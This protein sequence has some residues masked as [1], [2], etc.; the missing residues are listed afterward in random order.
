M[1]GPFRTQADAPGV[2]SDFSAFVERLLLPAPRHPTECPRLVVDPSGSGRIY[3]FSAFGLYRS[4]DRGE[5][6][7]HLS[8]TFGNGPFA[9]GEIRFGEIDHIYAVAGQTTDGYVAG[10]DSAGGLVFSTLVG[11]RNSD[12]VNSV[13]LAPGGD[14]LIGGTTRSD[15]VLMAAGAAVNSNGAYEQGFL[16]RLSA[17]GSALLDFR[18]IGGSA[19]DSIAGLALLSN[20]ELAVAG[21]SA[22]RDRP[23]VSAD[24]FASGLAGS[25]DGFLGVYSTAGFAP[26]FFSFLG[27]TGANITTVAAGGMRAYLLG[28]FIGQQ[29]VLAGAT[30]ACETPEFLPACTVFVAGLDL[31]P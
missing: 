14:I 7:A 5:A 15:D 1:A 23:D 12:A 31:Q 13:A 30:L 28:E 20:G 26:R 24:A 19:T 25:F 3:S 6:W 4:Q 8:G 16:A 22:S 11:G 21:R 10:V 2:L 27:S 17:D 9:R 18:Y 29:S